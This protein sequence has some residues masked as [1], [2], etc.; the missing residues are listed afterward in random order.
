M[1]QTLREALAVYEKLGA[2]IKDIDL[3]NN[4]LSVSAYYVVAP[5]E[6]SANLSRFDGVRYGY[7]CADPLDLE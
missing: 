5:A 3:P 6:A 4:H 7:R 2:T 1:E